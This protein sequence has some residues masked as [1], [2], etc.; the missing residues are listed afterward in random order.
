LA[1]VATAEN[2]HGND[3]NTDVAIATT[4]WVLTASRYMLKELQHGCD[5]NKK[6]SL[7]AA[8]TLDVAT[9]KTHVY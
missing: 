1:D 7:V 2:G 9:A 3:N 4:R 5:I 8:T 6:V